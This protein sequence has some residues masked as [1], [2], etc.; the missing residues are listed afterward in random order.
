[1]KTF[2]KV[3]KDEID[4]QRILDKELV[5]RANVITTDAEWLESTAA[6]E[7]LRLHDHVKEIIGSSEFI[8][9][10]LTV[11]ALAMGIFIA[12]YLGRLI[13]EPIVSM[14]GAMREIAAGNVDKPVPSR[15]RADEI[16]EMAE[17][18]EALR[19]EVA[20]AF[21]LGQ[22]VE[23]MPINV[24]MCD[25]K[26]F[27]ITYMNKSTATTL[28]SLE[29]LLPC[30]VDD[31][32]GQSVDIFHKEP[33]HQRGILS[34]PNNLPHNANIRLGDEYLA[35][36]VNAIY[37]KTGEYVGPMLTWAVVTEQVTLS[38]K[39]MGVVKN[40]SAAAAEMNTTAES[41][42]ATAQ[43]TSRRAATVATA[44]EQATS[45]VQTVASASEEM[46]ASIN[47]I[48]RQVGQS[49]EVATKANSEAER[50]NATV[51]GLAE[52]A[53]KIGE[54]VDLISEIAEQTNL[55]ALNATIEAARAGE[56][57][58]GFAVVASE[59]KNLANQ[60]AKATEEISS[61]VAEMQSVTGDAVGAIKG[62]GETIA[63]INLIAE[64][65]TAAMGEQGAATQEIAD[66]TQQAA[67]GTQEV[68][69]NITGVTQAASETG[70]A[71]QQVL[72]ASD[73]LT[74][75]AGALSTEVEAFLANVKAA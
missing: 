60:T 69:S 68:S 13:S 33:A 37:G 32:V 40:V 46:S 1:M 57:G 63:E 62:I 26:D 35:L 6:E 67:A 72:T 19:A 17:S 50:T 38:E 20:K 55:L 61:Q 5:V 45:N 30:K 28:K 73:E 3:H 59:V 16:G 27:T 65:I 39:V 64:A 75:Q 48:N 71:A 41:M 58:K 53:Q 18:L 14:T 29:K 11:A 31:L 23:D 56:A 34:D 70:T 42:S 21:Q 47:E 12:W 49:A 54:V 25:A 51:Q 7:E 22:M 43:E 24:M 52:A 44:S 66:N 15:D 74:K 10:I 2:D 36:N 8:S 4:L 9:V